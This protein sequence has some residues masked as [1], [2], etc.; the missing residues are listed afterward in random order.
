MEQVTQ[1]VTR[2]LSKARDTIVSLSQRVNPSIDTEELENTAVSLSIDW[3]L[4][5]LSLAAAVDLTAHDRY[6]DWYRMQFRGRKRLHSRDEES[7]DEKSDTG[8]NVSSTHITGART[9]TTRSSLYSFSEG[10]Q[11]DVV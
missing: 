9:V 8:S 10:C 7:K 3:K 4:V 11:A 5:R 6:Q 2:G 1:M